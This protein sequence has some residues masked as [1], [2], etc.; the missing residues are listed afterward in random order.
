MKLIP[1]KINS[2]KRI[3]DIFNDSHILFRK[4]IG[5]K[6]R[7][8]LNGKTIF[9]PFNWLSDNKAEIFWHMS[10]LEQ[11]DKLPIKPCTNDITSAICDSN[12]V[13]GSDTIVLTNGEV[14]TK[15]I[16]RTTRIGW[17]QEIVNMYNL[18]D[19]RVKYWEKDVRDHRRRIYLRYQE[20]EIDYL[21]VFEKKSEKRVVLITGYPVFFISAKKDLDKEFTD[22]QESIRKGVLK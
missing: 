2:S 8:S 7:P 20:E 16:Y 17:I 10:S 1:M 18:S 12:C 22:Y 14:R 6:S 21:V 11:K 5:S 9:I 13:N 19:T 3:E 15:C 4:T